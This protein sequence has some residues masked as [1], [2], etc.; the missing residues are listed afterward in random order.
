MKK[1][2]KFFLAFFLLC[3]SAN[4]ENYA[5]GGVKIFNYGIETS[6][7]QNLNTSLIALGFSS[8][9]SETDNT[10]VGFDIG[11]GF[12]IAE[13]F[14]VEGGYVN[15]GTLEIVTTLTG[16]SE[17]LTTEISGDGVTIAGVLDAEGF[18]VKAGMHSWDFTGTITASL[19]S[20]SQA[21]GTGTDPF[22]GIGFSSGNLISSLEH[23]VIDDG[24]I[25]SINLTYRMPF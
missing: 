7:L 24:D 9:K 1:I 10:G 2:S 25:Q 6:D 14:S 15:Y 22:F 21:L 4:A 20:S 13:G 11:M 18:Y 23:Y 19:G 17:K 3:S 5:Y 12:G 16:P 8:A